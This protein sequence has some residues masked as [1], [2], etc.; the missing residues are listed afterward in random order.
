VLLLGKCRI[1]FDASLYSVSGRNKDMRDF[2]GA[3]FL[4]TVELGV[5]V[6]ACM[7]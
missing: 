1:I 3:G 6:Y 4:K 5:Y 2:V 7:M